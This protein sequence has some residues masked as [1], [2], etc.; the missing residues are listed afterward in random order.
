MAHP[1][2]VRS[3]L[4]LDGTGGDPFIGDVAVGADG[5]IAALVPASGAS[6]QEVEGD[7]VVDGSGLALAPGFVDMHSHSDLY[8]L[9]T[10]GSSGPPIGDGPKLL[11]G[12][13]SQVFGQDGFSAAPVGAS[14]AA[15][16]ALGA[17]IAGLDGS[18][19]P[20]AWTWSSFG[21]YLAALRASAATRTAGLVGHSTIR[22]AAMGMEAR[23]PTEEELASMRSMVDASM[24]EGALGIST[25]LVYAPA[26][27]ASTAELVAL[28]EVVARHSGRFFVHVRSESDRV[29]EATEEVLEVAR[30]SGVHLH[31]SHI[32]AAGRGN[33]SLAGQIMAMVAD[34]R[35]RGVRVTADVHPYTAGSTTATVLLPPWVLEGGIAAA[36]ARLRDPSTRQRVRAQLLGD[37]TSWDNWLAF[38]GGW[39]GLYVAACRRP[40]TAG[41]PFSE[42]IARAGI[43]D[44]SSQE[45][46]DAVFDFLSGESLAASLISFNN[47]EDNIARFMAAPYCTIGSDA[48][49]NP[50]GHPHPRLYGTFPRVLGHYVRDLR[51]LSLHEAVHAMT[52]R[53]AAALGLGRGAASTI[54]PGERAD[55]VLFDPATIA[56][57][58]TYSEPRLPPVGIHRVWVGGETAAI[59]GLL[60]PRASGSPGAAG[61]AG[62]SELVPGGGQG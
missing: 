29:V 22:S 2:V 61:T 21:E 47:T 31:Y 50:G 34:Y 55:L 39:D 11:Q 46:F 52:G 41:R 24:R 25:G 15:R 58:S 35:K 26:A 16:T 54:A 14:L 51:A 32:K 38:S 20:A 57:R 7:V 33:W 53:A 37:T 9:V 27:Y 8:S 36:L 45:A 23:P 56:D 43:A 5:R 12:C 59:G 62:S 10:A 3:A 42:M 13:T 44:A 1:F 40:E 17:H 18:I 28:C 60:S 30:R 49:V 48:L 4:V 19:D 6:R